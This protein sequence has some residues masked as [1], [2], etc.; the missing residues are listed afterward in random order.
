VERIVQESRD[1]KTAERWDIEQQT[2]MT[3]TER[4]RAA[5]ILKD[6]SFPSDSRDVRECHRP[7]WTRRIFPPIHTPSS[8]SFTAAAFAT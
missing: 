4:L 7:G 6:R 3:R 2:A 5:R 8:S 1:Y